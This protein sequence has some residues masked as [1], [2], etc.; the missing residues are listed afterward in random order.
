MEQ[1]NQEIKL[2]NIS[3][4]DLYKGL[5]SSKNGLSSTEVAL[6]LK[7]FGYNQI[8][9]EKR[10][11]TLSILIRQFNNPLLW[12]LIFCTV[13]SL[14]IGDRLEASLILIMILMYLL[15]GF[16]QEYKTAKTF[17]LLK[18]YTISKN[19]VIRDNKT[20]EIDSKEIF[21]GDIVYLTSGDKVPADIR[22]I[23][24]KDLTV[25]ESSL[26]GESIPVEKKIITQENNISEPI[27]AEHMVFMGTSI[28]SGEAYGIV[29]IT[30]DQTYF[31]KLTQILQKKENITDFQKN[32]RKF[33]NLMIKVIIVMIFFIFLINTLQHK[34]FLESI[35]FALAIAIGITPELLPIILTITLARGARKMAKK[36]VIVKQLASMENLGN[37]DTLCC[38]K[39][40]TLTEGIFS[41]DKFIDIDGN[42]NINLLI[43]TLLCSQSIFKE[44]KTIFNNPMDSSIWEKVKEKNL[45]KELD[46]YQ[47]LDISEFN[48][49]KRRISCIIKKENEN[50]FL[51]K[52][53]PDN[54]LP[55][56]KFKYKTNQIK[57]L[58]DEEIYKIKEK[59]DEFEKDGYRVIIVAGK[60]TNINT[61]SADL[62]KDLTF[63]GYLIF[64]DPPKK[65]VLESLEKLN[66][67]RIN[68]KILTGDSPLITKKICTDLNINIIEDKIITGKEIDEVPEDKAYDFFY[69][70][71]IFARVNPE[72]K[73]RII[74]TLNQNDHIVGYLGDGIND[75]PALKIA[76]VG[77]SVSSAVEIAKD[78]ANIVLLQ[79]SLNVIAD[80]VIEGRKAFGNCTKYILNIISSNFGNIITL[81][82]FSFFL[83]FIPL[84]PSQI[85]LTNLITDITLSGLA[86][87]NVD[88]ELIIKPK[89]W[90]F[91]LITHFMIIFGIISTI[92]DVILLFL[93]IHV[94]HFDVR[95]F[96]SILFTFS[97]ISE[98]LITFMVRTMHPFYKSKPGKSLIVIS[99]VML[100][101]TI[102]LPYTKLGSK[103][104]QLNPIPNNIIL[105]MIILIILYCITVEISK[106]Y[107]FKKI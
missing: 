23:K 92:F 49:E 35:L 58:T 12:I 28:I 72:Q 80:G 71:N 61:I 22:L 81:E 75:T 99:I 100:F 85:L 63:F 25:D 66:S 60:S 4:D 93:L 105:P 82:I 37:M 53:S 21:P 32:I 69:K 9:R 55:L 11:K 27:D 67:L 83:P 107:F 50:I 40:G 68:I 46:K 54:I 42:E 44:E 77:I 1:N 45:I 6:R 52:G 78:A 98:L 3:I 64:I 18:Q 95:D 106:K 90:D 13:I 62:E 7:Q 16:F 10:E 26:T 101:F 89:K 102:I 47:V 8:T 38:D 59:I 15:L 88:R 48:F 39:T 5:N 87:D 43:E 24:L 17:E 96:R 34:N 2:W 103:I 79:K 29:I 65:G 51:S 91:K 73:Y 94:Y 56:C 14:F 33:G 74:K 30:G 86:N 31:G 104:F 36:K 41:L 84:L 57:E 20:L 97:L 19:K 70:Y 76:D